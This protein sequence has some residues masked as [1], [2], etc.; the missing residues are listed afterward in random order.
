M[1]EQQTASRA[2]VARTVA[3]TGASI[4]LLAATLWI[5]DTTQVA[6][7]LR[8]LD[9]SWML[10]ALALLAAQFPLLAARWW[11]FARRLAVPLAYPR[12]LAEYALA[13]LLNQVLPFGILGD[14]GRA[15][16]HVRS[17]DHAPAAPVVLAIVL[18]RASGQIALWLVVA[19][20][21][22][23][24]WRTL[25]RYLDWPSTAAR[26]DVIAMIGLGL[27]GLVG[28]LAWHR[29]RR[30][31]RLRGLVAGG[32]RALLGPGPALVHLP[33][34][35][36]LL[37]SHV[38]AFVAIAHGLGLRLPVAQAFAIV[39]LVLVATTVPTFVAGWGV[40]EA[41]LAGLY[42]VVGLRP[43]DG[44][45]IA[46]VYGSLGLLASTPGALA[47]GSKRQ[48]RARQAKAGS[49]SEQA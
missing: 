17:A 27:A 42:H 30:D 14:V 38:F 22:P 31:E 39:P 12:A 25:S 8:M 48:A 18:E 35:F 7:R 40:R 47:L 5:V 10:V 49:R 43:S 16:R 1:M 45:T 13:S 20:M 46:L 36:A 11:F 29:L 9:F 33:L 23:T 21:A 37:A 34:S 6:R 4:A 28:L 41:T 24:W 32:L 15:A 26:A 44:V 19:A 2:R 3:Q